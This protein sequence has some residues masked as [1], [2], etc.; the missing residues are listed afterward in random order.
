VVVDIIGWVAISEQ[1]L[2]SQM[3]QYA[4]ASREVV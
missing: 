1:K 3:A 2:S 4:V